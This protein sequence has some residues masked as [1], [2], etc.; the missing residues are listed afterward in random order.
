VVEQEP[1]AKTC[2][3]VVVKL[4]AAGSQRST[5]SG[6]W[7]VA[8]DQKEDEPAHAR[9]LAGLEISAEMV[10]SAA[11]GK[12]PVRPAGARWESRTAWAG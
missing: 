9:I 8:S 6:P 3:S 11:Q 2:A 7:P 4:S 5:A 1:Y 10:R 12:K